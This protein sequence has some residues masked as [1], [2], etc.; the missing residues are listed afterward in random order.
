M[1]MEMNKARLRKDA[2]KEGWKVL[3]ANNS[4]NMRGEDETLCPI[5]AAKCINI[6]CEPPIGGKLECDLLMCNGFC[7]KAI[8]DIPPAASG[9]VAAHAIYEAKIKG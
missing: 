6:E 8:H 3:G 1:G 5:C 4:Q 7:K 9:S 2:K